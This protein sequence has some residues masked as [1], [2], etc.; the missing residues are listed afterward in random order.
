MNISKNITSTFNNYVVLL[1][2]HFIE[3]VILFA[4]LAG[5]ILHK[6]KIIEDYSWVYLCPVFACISFAVNNLTGESR[7]YIYYLTLIPAIGAA[8]SPDLNEWI[9]T[10]KYEITTFILGPLLIL[11]CNKKTDN[12]SFIRTCMKYVFSTF[13]AILLSF[14]LWLLFYLI[15]KSVALIF[16]DVKGI[17]EGKSLYYMSSIVWIFIAPSLFMYLSDSDYS[18]IKSGNK[19]LD[20]LFGYIISPAVIIYSAILYIYFAVIVINAEFPKGS[21]S[22]MVFVFVMIGILKKAVTPFMTKNIVSWFFRYFSYISLPAIIMFWMAVFRRINEFG[23]TDQRVY[24][25]VCGIIMTFAVII[26]MFKRINY[27]FYITLLAFI[28][29]TVIT[30]IPY[31]SAGDITLHSQYERAEKII[32]ETGIRDSEG[33]FVTDISGLKEPEFAD[34]IVSLYSSVKIIESKDTVMLQSMGLA[35]S[36][37]LKKMY[38]SFFNHKYKY[39]IISA[40]P[41]FI[42]L[43]GYSYIIKPKEDNYSEDLQNMNYRYTNDTLSVRLTDNNIFNISG[44]KILKTQMEKVGLGSDEFPDEDITDENAN[45]FLVYKNDSILIRFSSITFINSESKIWDMDIEYILIK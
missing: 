23:Y 40:T 11:L 32:I 38:P 24:L 1:K 21:I 20:I 8:F 19:F 12:K 44:D 3:S 10:Y 34:R 28:S 6:E 42:S 31:F 26:L 43:S 18:K 45:N 36:N 25:V 15:I 30:Y 22:T 33:N 37:D 5:V 9:R 17:A 39:N 2:N 13:I 27:Y 7:R 41:E 35:K 29:L 4:T 14:I 16:P